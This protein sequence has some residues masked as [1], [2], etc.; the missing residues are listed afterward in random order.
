MHILW[1][2]IEEQFEEM[3]YS[4]F[5]PLPILPKILS[6]VSKRGFSI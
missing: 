3:L 6:G 1:L 2:K 4:D 5:P